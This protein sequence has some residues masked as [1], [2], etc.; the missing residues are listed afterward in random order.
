MSGFT[1]RDARW[2]EDE[3]A[4]ILF[5]DGLQMYEG[6]FEANRRTDPQ[7]GSDYFAVLINRVADREGRVFVAEQ[8]GIAV[9][10]AVFLVEEEPVYIVDKDRRAGM[11]AELYVVQNA[12][13]AGIGKSLLVACEAEASRRG[14]NVLLIG[15]LQKNTRPAPSIWGRDSHPMPTCCANASRTG[16][17][18]TVQRLSFLHGAARPRS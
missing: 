15:V 3:A 14:A 7:V 8:D 12:R 16:W 5:I 10:W 17:P 1:I 13:G 9:G 2:P 4:A 18:R 11:V 6:E